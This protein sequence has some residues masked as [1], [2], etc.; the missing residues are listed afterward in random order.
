MKILR[1]FRENYLL[2]SILLVAAILRFV[3]VNPGYNPYHGDET[4]IWGSALDMIRKSTL[5]PGRYD[6]P[7]TSILINAFFYKF[8]FVPA[9]WVWYYLTHFWQLIDGTIKIPPIPEDAKRIFTL[10][11]AGERGVNSIFWARYVTAAFGVGTVFL[12]YLLAKKMFSQKAGFVAALFLTFNYRN[13][14]NSHLALPDI[15]NAF[16]LLLALIAY[17]NL[18]QKPSRL[19]Y[20]L[21][22]ISCGLALS[23]KYQIFAVVPLIFAHLYLTFKEKFDLKKLFDTRVVVAGLCIALVLLLTNPYYLINFEQAWASNLDDIRKYGMGTNTLNLF[24]LSY[25]YHIDY[26]PI[27]SV[28]VGLG[29]LIGLARRTLRSF[30]L[31]SVIVP[32]LYVFLYYSKGGFYVRNF[33]IVT[34][35]L[36]IFASTA[37]WQLG[38]VLLSKFGERIKLLF[39]IPAIALTVYIPAKNSIISSYAYT[40]P[41][42]YEI[43]RPWIQENIP[44]DALVVVHPFDRANLAM[45]N[46]SVEYTH[47]GTYSVAESIEKNAT[48]GVLNLSWTSAPF[49]SWMFYGFDELREFWNKPLDS[50]KNTYF[51]IATGE[52]FRY[53]IHVLGKPWQAP[54]H[55][56]VVVKLPQ[57]PQ[58]PMQT[59]KKFSFDKDEE[60]WKIYG[61]KTQGTQ[62]IKF[63]SNTGSN[64]PGSLLS[65]RLGGRFP[66][67]RLTSRP[68]AIKEDH[69]YVIKGFLKTDRKLSARERDGFLRIDFYS[70]NPNL[71]NLGIRTDVSS[72]VYD[73]D[74]WTMKK[75]TDVA[76]KGAKFMTVSVS[77]GTGR[78]WADDIVIEESIDEVTDPT[79]SPPYT[80]SLIDPSYIYPNSHGNL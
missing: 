27:E 71:E 44:P 40:K 79:T 65:V 7:A 56:F 55:N 43:L 53:Q 23:I 41:W 22:G 73:T 16:F 38:D 28:L 36:L 15:Y 78:V 29:I 11:I 21:A 5:D 32:V 67:G 64:Y 66:T 3:A 68:I 33:I 2:A 51:G 1:W 63:D 49:Y 60:G 69:L 13:V 30:S 14:M 24:P 19:T 48:Y 12:T 76:P 37:F 10:Y 58:V 75:I 70:D 62:E 74:S 35:L 61:V 59:L 34:P 9:G 17:W 4:A 26:G 42:N 25:L 20:I 54:D 18:L 72:R 46:K 45:K 39:I 31:L 77:I 57:W 8:F 52:L 50:L 80:K 6:Y 47:D